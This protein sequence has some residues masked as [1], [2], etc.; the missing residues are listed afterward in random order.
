L[1]GGGAV[2][3]QARGNKPVL[4]DFE[5][6]TFNSGGTGARPTQDGLDATAFP[7]GVR[8]MP[9][10]ATENVAPVV[11]WRKEL[12]RIPAAP[13]A[14]AAASGRS[15]RSP[16]RAIWN[17]PSTRCFDRVANA[18]K[19]REGGGDGAP[20]VV[21]LK[22]GDAA[23]QGVPGHPRRRAADP[24]AAGRRRH[25]RCGDARPRWWRATCATGWC[26]WRSF[27]DARVLLLALNYFGIIT[28][29]L[30][31]LIFIPQI[32]KSIG[33]TSNMTV[34]WLTMIPYIFGTI[35]LVV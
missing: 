11:F 15:W 6:I 5:I 35:S 32:I 34:G 29:S 12:R 26:V 8:T 14:R 17:S 27:F 2:S 4:P 13:G 18:P 28:A 24:A 21:A 7:S 10:E 25:G 20:G 23:H 31:Q 9:V 1:R 19:G 3:G 16:P 33:V 22:S 30:G